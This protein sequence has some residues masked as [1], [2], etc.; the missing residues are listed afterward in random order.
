LE[1]ASLRKSD[2][3]ADQAEHK[4]DCGHCVVRKMKKYEEFKDETEFV[5]IY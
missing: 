3:Q 2:V 1:I 4:F 5:Y